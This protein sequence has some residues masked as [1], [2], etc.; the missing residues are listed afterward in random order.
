MPQLAPRSTLLLFYATSYEFLLCVCVILLAISVASRRNYYATFPLLLEIILR[1][2]AKVWKKNKK[3][4]ALCGKNCEDGKSWKLK[5]A[6][7]FFHVSFSVA[8]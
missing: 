2:Q 5:L 1:Q 6:Q 3:K 8:K 7:L 4:F